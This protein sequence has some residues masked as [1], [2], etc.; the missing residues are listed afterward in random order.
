MNTENVMDNNNTRKHW[1][2]LALCLLLLLEPA[3]TAQTAPSITLTSEER[4]WL[5]NNPEKLVLWYN[6]EFPPVEFRAES[7]TFTGLGADIIARIE[8]L[9]SITFIKKSSG[10]WNAHL[11]ALKTGECAV[12][13]T[14]V[15]T[16]ER[17]TYAFFTTPYA[18]VPV[19]IITPNTNSETQT[20]DHFSHRKIAVVSGYATEKY[21][22]DHAL[23]SLFE[24]IA[25]TDVPEGLHQVA[26]GQVD[27]FV[28]N[29][30]VAAYY[31]DML[32][33]P[34]LRVAG[35]TDFSFA[36]SIGVSRQYPL[37]YSSIHKALNSI[38]EQDHIAMREKWIALKS[39]LGISSET[40][41]LIKASALFAAMLLISLAVITFLLKRRLNQKVADLQ[42]SEVRYRELI[43][44]ANSIIL[45]MNSEGCITFFNEF[46]QRFFGYT[47]DEVLGK[48]V[49]GTIVPIT[50][51]AG[52]DLKTMIANIGRWPE[53]YALNENENIRRDG[54]HVFIFW[55][56]RPLFNSAGEI[57]EIL[58][59]GNDI[60]AS[61]NAEK[62]LREAEQKYRNLV[63]HSQSII[64]TIAADGTFTFASPSWQATL[65]HAPEEVIGHNFRPFV[66]TDDLPACEEFLRLTAETGTVQPGVEYRVFHKNGSIRWHRSVIT[67]AYDEQRNLTLFVGNAVDITER[68]QAE[69]I[70]KQS[71]ERFRAIV[72]QSPF[73]II[74]FDPDGNAVHV[75]DAH[76]RLWGTTREMAARYNV[77]NDP[78]METLGLWPFFRCAFA[79]EQLSLPPL[80][81]DLS[82]ILG[83]GQK[84]TV[85]GDFYPIRDT[86]GNVLSL[87]VVHQ[88]VTEEERN[89][90]EKIQLQEQLQHALKMEAIGRLAGGVAHDFNNMLGVILGH[91]EL[92]LEQINPDQPLFADLHE[93]RK[94]AKRS[95]DLTQQLLAFARKQTI[96]PKVLDLNET[97]GGML[98]MLR[99]L[100]GEDIVL[101][102]I[103]GKNLGPIKIDPSQLDQI[104][105]NLCVN[106]R[107]AI[108]DTG[109]IVIA[110]AT[111]SFDAT[112]C[113][114]HAGFFPGDYILLSISDDGLGMDQETLDKLFEPF[115]TTKE[116]GKGTGLG[117]A[118]VYGI[119]KQNNGFITVDST[120]GLGS[121]FKIYLPLQPGTAEQSPKSIPE[122]AAV[123]GQE[124]I[125]LV[126]DEPGILHMA[127]TM[128]E[129]LGYN[130]VGASSPR[131]AVRLTEKFA[132]EIHLIMTDVIMP[133][134]NGR[135][136][137]SQLLRR[138]PNLKSLFMSGYTAD[139][140]AHHGVLNEAVHFIEKPFTMKDLAAKVREALDQA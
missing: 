100:I 73:A 82:A 22:R 41:R 42:E 24:V 91:T 101:D 127:K 78:Q 30:A 134:M 4:A 70:L 13:P 117:L 68:K 53:R 62:A 106:A 131:E 133:G 61:K 47:A 26:F 60:T 92:A 72:D 3:L 84:K 77:F 33:I 32:G 87:I 11:A 108:T 79:G 45:R 19:V 46:A 2:R 64:Y 28:E 35:T 31:I 138:Y 38:P 49:I 115:F 14:I 135:D 66:H 137:A 18:T 59:I 85:L 51:S 27:A 76:L 54:T 136:L 110:T 75:N 36:W 96:T 9:L 34:N 57:S 25:V 98:K 140:I 121:S 123:R 109:K 120:P 107:D 1:I 37:L 58:C 105:A 86:S 99:R 94:A 12:A 10:D 103:P 102:W 69:E 7:G 90:R 119:V 89:K 44:N 48:N 40:L 126:E 83:S 71:E 125:L 114:D 23:L 95:A 67:P 139:V 65:G 21:L 81:Y 43:E 17:E 93:I 55:A 112:Y 56:N 88:D 97:M 128:L 8:T 6:I 104:L 50:D 124:T 130:V 132:G 74:V 111:A 52:N 15:R 29:L 5:D 116:T 80:E 122:K 39:N 118:T 113:S 20:L 63:D 16:P 129:R